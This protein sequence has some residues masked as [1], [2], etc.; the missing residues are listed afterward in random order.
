MKS[1]KLK[2]SEPDLKWRW[3]SSKTMKSEADPDQ[4]WSLTSSKTMVS[5]AEPDQN[6]RLRGSEQWE[7]G[8][9]DLP[10]TEVA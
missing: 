7:A 2:V 10:A 3:K 5:E 9:L 4:K 1:S 6:W 8:H